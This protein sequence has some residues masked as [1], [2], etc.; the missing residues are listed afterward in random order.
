MRGKG[1]GWAVVGRG[2]VNLKGKLNFYYLGLMGKV[3]GFVTGFVP[4][5]QRLC[6]KIFSL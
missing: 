1:S 5:G 6:V 2:I 3:R 4:V